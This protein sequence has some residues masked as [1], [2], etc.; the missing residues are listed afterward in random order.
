M[1]F[2]TFILAFFALINIIFSF[3]KPKGKAPKRAGKA[4]AGKKHV[5]AKAH[6]KKAKAKKHFF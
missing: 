3:E 6:A 1:K 5:K 2:L 4:K